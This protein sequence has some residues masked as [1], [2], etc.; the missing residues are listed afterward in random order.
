L[1]TSSE[2]E[3]RNAHRSIEIAVHLSNRT[4]ELLPESL[5]LFLRG[6][7]SDLRVGDSARQQTNEHRTKAMFVS[8]S[9]GSDLRLS[10]ALDGRLR[11]DWRII[12]LF[13]TCTTSPGLEHRQNL[14]MPVVVLVERL[15]VAQGFD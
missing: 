15:P 14:D 6:R 9:L 5:L 7:C 10:Q 12:D 2:I 11:R 8:R 1:C 4:L 13:E 3:D